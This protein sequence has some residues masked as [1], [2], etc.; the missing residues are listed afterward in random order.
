M[1]GWWFLLML[2]HL[3]LRYPRIQP[4][5]MR[6]H[7]QHMGGVC[8]C[9]L[10]A[11]DPW[12]RCFPTFWGMGIAYCIGGAIWRQGWCTLRI[13]LTL[14]IWLKLV[15][16]DGWNLGKHWMTEIVFVFFLL[17][18]FSGFGYCLYILCFEC[19]FEKQHWVVFFPTIFYVHPEPWGRWT[20]CWLAHILS[21]GV[22]STTS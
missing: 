9:S 14:R 21:K 20:P 1:V 11:V 12:G 2:R 7:Q 10:P 6:I 4:L 16:L 15:E 5:T 17:G 13:C 19:G 18:L 3:I 8:V 22:G